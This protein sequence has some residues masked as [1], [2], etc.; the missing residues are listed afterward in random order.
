[1]LN[2]DRLCRGCMTDNGGEDICSLCGYEK[3]TQNGEMCL[4]VSFWL[5]DRFLVGKVISTDSEGITYIGWD[6]LSDTAVHIKEYFPQSIAIRNPD[7]TVSMTDDSKFIFND[8]LMDFLS[9]NRKL[10]GLEA[11]SVVP[12]V[13]VFE[14]NS[15]AY[16]VHSV[17]SGI[18]LTEFLNKNGGKLKW[19]QAR[20]LFLPVIDTLVNL[21]KDGIRHYGISPDTIIVGRD[22]KMRLSDLVINKVRDN[23]GGFET[24]L[25]A[26]YSA[27]EQYGIPEIKVS[28]ATDV[29]GLA[30]TLFR[31]LIGITPPEATARMEQDTLSIPSHFAEELPR[32]VL[33]SLANGMQIMP[34]KRTATL[35]SFRNE[36]VYG[37]IGDG[38]R[39]AQNNQKTEQSN[40]STKKKKKSSGA[41]SALISALITVLCLCIIGGGIFF[42]FKDKIFPPEEPTTSDTAPE[43]LPDTPNVGDVDSSIAQTVTKIK[44]ENYLGKLYS[45]L[46]DMESSKNFKFSVSGREH[47]DKYERG[48]IIRQ[49]INAGTEVERETEISFTISLGPKSFAVGK[50][51]GMTEAEAKISLLQKGILYDNIRVIS[52]YDTEKKPGVVIEQS[53][54]FGETVTPD[55]VVEISVN[56]YKGDE[57]PSESEE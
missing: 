33:V 16:A 41:K 2:T 23:A 52:V 9:L 4:P 26:G 21:H 31:V 25:E 44:V 6:N 12:T 36:L 5:Q 47:S 34:E 54:E 20:P 17:I 56:D 3:G 32:A 22:G 30:A 57:E 55:S 35:D 8:G 11:L 19:E 45:E 15:T 1:M 10:F 37:E 50:V 49:S 7:L 27:A 46:E 38:E 40:R 43:S 24:Q 28:E 18:T 48:E 51:V 14:E 39:T 53:P 42:I 13:A 29:Y